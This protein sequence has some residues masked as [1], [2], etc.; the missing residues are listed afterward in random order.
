MPA[1]LTTIEP[2]PVGVEAGRLKVTELGLRF[3]LPVFRNMVGSLP[4]VQAQN[5]STATPLL[6]SKPLPLI[7]TASPWIRVVSTLAVAKLGS[8]LVAAKPWPSSPVILGRPAAAD[9]CS[10]A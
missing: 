8:M 6:T 5:T 7:T 2:G 3:G 9:P 1:L 4:P 10:S